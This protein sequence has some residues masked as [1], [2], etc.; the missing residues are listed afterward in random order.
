VIREYRLVIGDWR[1]T[2]LDDSA[3]AAAEQFNTVHCC[4]RGR[5]F[6]SRY[7]ISAV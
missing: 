7:V 1:R 4:S 6:P 3:S 5:A 2:T